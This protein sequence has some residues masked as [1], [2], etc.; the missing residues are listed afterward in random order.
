[1]IVAPQ[2]VVERTGQ[3]LSDAIE[4]AAETFHHPPKM[5]H[6]LY[7]SKLK[8]KWRQQR[9][10]ITDPTGTRY[11]AYLVNRHG[12]WTKLFVGGGPPFLGT[13]CLAAN[14]QDKN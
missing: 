14:C 10:S 6:R 8:E 1:M 5:M 13:V 3:R 11:A 2:I 7:V 4:D 12:V 9:R